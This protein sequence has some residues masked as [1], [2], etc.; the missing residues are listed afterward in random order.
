[1]EVIVIVNAPAN[2]TQEVT[3]TNRRTYE[4]ALEWTA[5]NAAEWLNFDIRYIPDMP[6][7]DA[8]AGLARKTG[9]DLAAHRLME[10]GRPDG[11]ISSLDAD[12]LVHHTYLKDIQQLFSDNPGCN[13]CTTFFEHPVQGDA[14]PPEIYGAIIQYELHLRYYVQA[15]RFAGFPYAFHTVGSCFSVRASVYLRQGGMNKRKAGED[16]YFLHKLM[17]LGGVFELNSTCVYPSPRPSHRVPFGTG[18]FISKFILD[19]EQEW[20]TYH[21]DA[22]RDLKDFFDKKDLLYHADPQTLRQ[23]CEKLSLS[24]REFVSG[25]IFDKLDEINSNSSGRSAFNKR[26]FAWFN[27]FR[28]LKYL[29][30]A[31]EHYF[32]RITV[33]RAINV[34][35]ELNLAASDPKDLL[36]YL[37]KLQR[38]H[39][40]RI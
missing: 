32:T 6:P 18:P 26:F 2:A 5:G 15:L 38:A 10:H 24:I 16:F 20:Q 29:N 7:R 17:P 11:I 14:F 1:V 35:L 37:R 33:S 3:N 21:L 31:H 36:L 23:V 12:T 30:F 22:F 28:V 4:E 8:G 39:E 34:L 9:M 25:Q 13:A 27:A 19:R 40:Y